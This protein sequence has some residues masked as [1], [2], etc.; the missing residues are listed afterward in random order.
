MRGGERHD[1]HV[2][3]QSAR[4]AAARPIAV[5]GSITWPASHAQRI[6]SPCVEIDPVAGEQLR[7]ALALGIGE[8]H[9]LARFEAAHLLGQRGAVAAA[10]IEQQ[11]LEI[12]ETWMS[13][14]GARVGVTVPCE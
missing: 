14:D 13:I 6:A 9:R 8:A 3:G 5:C 2:G 4:R 10:E 12:G 11:P 1:R 7:G